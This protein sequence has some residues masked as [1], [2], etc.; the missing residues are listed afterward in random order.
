MLCSDIK[1][2]I[3]LGV[4][5]LQVES[6]KVLPGTQMRLKAN[7]MGLK[8]SPLPPY[9]ILKTSS[10]S[11]KEIETTMQISRMLDFYYNS[12]AWQKIT[13]ELTCDN[14]DFIM[15]FTGYLRDSMVLD[16]PLSLER[17]GVIIYEYC[18]IN[19]PDKLTDISLAWIEAGFSLKKAPAGDIQKI[20]NPEAF[21]EE[22]KYRLH[23]KYGNADP[24]HRY[25]LLK[26]S[27][28]NFIF[29]YDSQLHQPSPV[30]LA[31]INF[32]ILQKKPA[33]L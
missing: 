8:Y 13:R 18:K 24:Y 33:K 1:T 23:I 21:L 16:S 9:E 5:E 12:K 29:G 14:D 11:L 31:T 15:R 6:L 27:D 28:R 7:E 32:T 2:L 25:Y 20:K 3:K 17:R 30:F 19:H 4:D 22:G 10:I 26:S